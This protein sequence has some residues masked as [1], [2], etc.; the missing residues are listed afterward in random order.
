MNSK[1]RSNQSTVIEVRREVPCGREYWLRGGTENLLGDESFVYLDSGGDYVGINVF[2]N[3][4]SHILKICA[5]CVCYIYCNERREERREGKREGKERGRSSSLP[6]LP[7]FILSFLPRERR[8]RR[9]RK[10]ERRRGEGTNQA[11]PG[12]QGAGRTLGG[13]QP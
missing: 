4:S 11:K 6:S 9:E 7:P 12:I 13:Y 3:S 10:G 5:P 8:G 2:K 1:N